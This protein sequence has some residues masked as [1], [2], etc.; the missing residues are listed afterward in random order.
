V[1]PSGPKGA[2]GK[3]G[4]DGPAGPAGKDGAVGQPGHPGSAGAAGPDGKPGKDGAPGKDGLNGKDGDAFF[5]SSRLLVMCCIAPR[6]VDVGAP[7]QYTCARLHA[8]SLRRPS[9]VKGLRSCLQAAMDPQ[10]YYH[11]TRESLGGNPFLCTW[12]GAGA[13]GKPGVDGKNGADGKVGPAG[14]AGPTG[15]EG[16]AHS[17]LLFCVVFAFRS[18]YELWQ[19]PKGSR[20]L[21]ERTVQT[22]RTVM[23]SSCS[24]SLLVLCW[25]SCW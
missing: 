17:T 6:K 20:A 14:P 16:A 12:V 24:L 23:L 19:V 10:G 2:D 4:K 9:D 21:T 18:D 11:D 7:T 5:I 13:G 15:K 3:D 8:Q 22:A 1:G 25:Q